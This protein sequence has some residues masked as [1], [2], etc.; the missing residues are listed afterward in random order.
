MKLK[1]KT[2]LIIGTLASILSGYQKEKNEQEYIRKQ[3]KKTLRKYW[4]L[5]GNVE[6]VYGVMDHIS[7]KLLAQAL[8][9]PLYEKMMSLY[10]ED[11]LTD[12]QK[13]RRQELIEMAKAKLAEALEIE[14][15]NNKVN[16]HK[17]YILKLNVLGVDVKL[18]TEILNERITMVEAYIDL[19]QSAIDSFAGGKNNA[20]IGK[21]NARLKNFNK[22]LLK[23]VEYINNNYPEEEFELNAT[24]D[25]NSFTNPIFNEDIITSDEGDTTKRFYTDFAN[26]EGELIP[27][28]Q[29]DKNDVI[30]LKAIIKNLDKL[31]KED[32]EALVKAIDTNGD[33]F[34]NSDDTDWLTNYVQDQEE[35]NS[36]RENGE[37]T[38]YSENNLSDEARQLITNIVKGNYHTDNPDIP[39]APVTQTVPSSSDYLYNNQ[40]VN[41]EETPDNGGETPIDNG[42]TPN[43]N[44]EETTNDN[45]ETPNDN[46]EETIN[47]NGE[48][49][50]V[51]VGD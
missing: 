37:Y 20:I 51:N 22:R 43:D 10:N 28:G 24:E 2:T 33:G 14:G 41:N 15:Y 45:G 34:L 18:T 1:E 6:I 30:I 50:D 12:D 19:L 4:Q 47:D 7:W 21:F 16:N 11:D 36:Q 38:P 3:L 29:I 23:I 9:S 42:E 46:G 8:E 17:E 31:S 48:T 26:A 39:E 13:T 27:D 49:P 44:G 25:K 40:E 32:K 35:I 5:A